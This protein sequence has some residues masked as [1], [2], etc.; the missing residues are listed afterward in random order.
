MKKW[1]CTVCNFIYDEA[2]GFPDEGIDPGTSW[3]SISE[4]WCCPECGV[5]KVE[6][7]MIPVN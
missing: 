4:D 2:L 1:R 3:E 7:E 6:F 5:S